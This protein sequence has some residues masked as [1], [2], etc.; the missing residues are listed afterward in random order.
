M[1]L[2]MRGRTELADPERHRVECF[3]PGLAGENIGVDTLGDE[4]DEAQVCLST[5][6]EA[7]EAPEGHLSR[8]QYPQKL[9]QYPQKLK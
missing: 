9:R 6:L 2:L 8:T 4:A 3:L 1:S 7:S 5:E